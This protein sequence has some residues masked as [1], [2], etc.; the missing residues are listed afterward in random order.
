MASRPIKKHSETVVEHGRK[1][2]G[3]SECYCV[4]DDAGRSLERFRTRFE[5]TQRVRAESLI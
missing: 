3:R 5:E 1:M 2:T 4:F